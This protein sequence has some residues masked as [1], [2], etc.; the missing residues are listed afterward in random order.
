[1][2]REQNAMKGLWAS[3]RFSLLWQRESFAH[4]NTAAAEGFVLHL[5]VMINHEAAL[6]L[7]YLVSI[8]SSRKKKEIPNTMSCVFPWLLSRE[9]QSLSGE[10]TQLDCTDYFEWTLS[11]KSNR[12]VWRKRILETKA[13]SNCFVCRSHWNEVEQWLRCSNPFSLSKYPRL[14]TTCFSTI[15]KLLLWSLRTRSSFLE[16]KVMRLKRAFERQRIAFPFRLWR[17][18]LSYRKRFVS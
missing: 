1:M 13:L 5:R 2:N 10:K 8:N 12:I 4:T 15:S 3:K 11:L 17:V 18:S 6:L 16:K 9:T 14:V 7:T